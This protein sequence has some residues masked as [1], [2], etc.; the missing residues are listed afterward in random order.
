MA[1]EDFTDYAEEDP[2]TDITK[3][4]SRITT[5]TMRRDVSAYVYKDKGSGHFSGNFEHKVD[6]RL[7]AAGTNYGTVIHW[8]LANSIG[9]EDEVAADGNNINVQ[10]VRSPTEAFYIL[11][12]E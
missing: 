10:T 6:V 11:I 7:T 4:A 3:T 8:A 5:D 9:D 1:I 12:R 2:N